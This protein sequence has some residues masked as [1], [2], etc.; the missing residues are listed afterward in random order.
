MAKILYLR[1]GNDPE[2]VIG[3]FDIGLEKLMAKAGVGKVMYYVNELPSFSAEREDLAR[4][5][6]PSVVF[7]QILS[8][9]VCQKFPKEGFYLLQEFK[10]KEANGWS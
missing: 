5:L 10:P 6:G 1:K 3:G 2:R 4:V 9:E 8:G 7:A